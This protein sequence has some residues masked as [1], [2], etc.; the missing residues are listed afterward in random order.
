MLFVKSTDPGVQVVSRWFQ[1]GSSR[2]GGARDGNRDPRLPE[3]VWGGPPLA[4]DW[5]SPTP[6]PSIGDLEK[7]QSSAPVNLRP[8]FT[9]PRDHDEQSDMRIR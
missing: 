3:R 4:C 8:D 2:Y 6:R 9:S 5:P 1:G 7:T